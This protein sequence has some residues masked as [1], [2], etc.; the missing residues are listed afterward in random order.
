MDDLEVLSI[1]GGQAGDVCISLLDLG[2]DGVLLKVEPCSC[3]GA[4]R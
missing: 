2:H 3:V 4:G 1:F